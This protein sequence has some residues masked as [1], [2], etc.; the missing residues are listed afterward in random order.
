MSYGKTTD[1]IS[2]CV[3]PFQHMNFPVIWI[4]SVSYNADMYV[5]LP[6]ESNSLWNMYTAYS[7][8]WNKYAREKVGGMLP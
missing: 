1:W 5:D 6:R 3:W 4:S 7:G 2:F 8:M